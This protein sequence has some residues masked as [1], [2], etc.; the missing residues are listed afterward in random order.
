MKPAHLTKSLFQSGRQCHKRLWL[1]VHRSELMAP[2]I[3]TS[4]RAEQNQR[5]GAILR[6]QFGLEAGEG[7]GSAPTVNADTAVARTEALLAEPPTH[8]PLLFDAAFE[9]DGVSVRVDVLMRFP[10]ADRLIAAKVGSRPTDDDYWNCALQMWVTRCNSRPVQVVSLA[11]IDNRVYSGAGD[12]GGWL[13]L[14]DCTEKVEALMPAVPGLIAKFA[15]VIA[16][17][18]P[19]LTTGP[20]CHGPFECPFL[21][22]CRASN[23][24]CEEV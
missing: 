5:F 22:H 18:L 2:N 10:S 11:L 4:A 17:P 3:A 23:S 13:V 24:L 20:Q 8:R 7:H 6:Q 19:D 9:Y 14:E 16:G 21:R 15:D 12:Y 1:E